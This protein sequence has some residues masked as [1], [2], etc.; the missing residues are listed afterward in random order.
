[1][2]ARDDAE[3]DLGVGPLEMAHVL[4]MDIVS[5][6]LLPIDHQRDVI[7]QLQRLVRDLPEVQRA[8]ESNELICLPT[9]DGMALVFSGD[10]TAPLR[11]ARRMA[12]E[13]KENARF[14]LR[15]GVHSGPVYRLADVNT[16]KNVAGG[17]INFAQRVMDCGDGGHILVSK[18][19]AE[20]L[21]QLSNWKASLHDLG[22]HEVKHG[23][24][25][26]LFNVFTEEF[27]NSKIPTRITPRDGKTA[28]PSS[29]GHGTIGAYHLL[30]RVGEGGLGQVWLAEQK[31]PVRRR[32][33][34]KLIKAGMDTH[35]VVARFSSERQ[36]LA[37]MD[38][39]TIAK[40]FDGGSTQEGKPY[41]VM[42]YVPG[43]PITEYCDKHK[44]DGWNCSCTS[45]REC[46][47]RIRKPSFIAI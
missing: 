7:Q 22:E 24:L 3:P 30:E 2:H 20:T 33:A 18:S 1:M 5:Y 47:T 44:L 10:P 36:A 37:L 17:G 41:F 42:E 26:H 38:H 46:S 32:V 31:V 39:P 9:G 23:V 16:N 29:S 11:C 35:E 13:M 19:V 12:L 15:M 21:L 8:L 34:L 28:G 40:V 43:I 4:F 14:E 25:V 6:S 45:A 27:G